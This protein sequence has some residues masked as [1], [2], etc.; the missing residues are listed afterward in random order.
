LRHRRT[1]EE[2]PLLSARHFSAAQREVNRA[3]GGKNIFGGEEKEIP[4]IRRTVWTI[5]E[6]LAR[7]D[8]SYLKVP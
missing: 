8:R 1:L 4:V 3:P 2:F 7:E 6:K 5:S